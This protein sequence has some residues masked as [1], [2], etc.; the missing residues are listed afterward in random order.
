MQ[1]PPDGPRRTPTVGELALLVVDLPGVADH[2]AVAHVEDGRGCCR[3]CLLPQTPP[4]VWPCTLAAVA[5]Q[6]RALDR[7]RRFPPD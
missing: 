2:L 3:G 1:E 6:A 5:R 7:A 4:A